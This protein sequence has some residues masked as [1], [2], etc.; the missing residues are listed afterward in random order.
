MRELV[1][2]LH[3]DATTE[4]MPNDG[5]PLNVQHGQQVPH[6]IGIGRDRVVGAWLIGLSMP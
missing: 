4:R 5:D 1:G 3:G 6:A 2:E